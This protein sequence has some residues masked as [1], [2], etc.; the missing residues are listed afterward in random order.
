MILPDNS[1]ALERA[2]LSAFENLT[3]SHKNPYPDLLNPDTCPVDKLDYLAQERLVPDWNSNASEQEKRDTIKAAIGISRISG[4]RQAIQL[5]LSPL[6]G[7]ASI[8][9]TA[10]YHLALNVTLNR[11]LTDE[12]IRRIRARIALAI[13]ARD[14]YSLSVGAMLHGQNNACLAIHATH[15]TVI[16][17]FIE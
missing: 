9:V 6:G 10:P 16:T 1:S 2:L 7:T 4:T 5:A 17:Q 12:M 15:K 3:Y 14:T 11:S 8:S 13:S